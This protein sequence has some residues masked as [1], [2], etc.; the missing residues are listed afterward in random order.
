M[1]KI[2]RLAYLALGLTGLTATAQQSAIYTNGL[3]DFNHAVAL[4]DEEQYLA[5]QLLFEKVKNSSSANYTEVQADCAYYI[6]NCAIRLD[7]VGAE[8]K[9]DEFVKNYPTSAK[10]N[11]A[12]VDVTDY[13]FSK[14][15]YAKALQYAGK[16]RSVTILEHSKQD[17]FLFQ[18]GYSFFYVK[19]PKEA[20]KTLLKVRPESQWGDQATYY[21]G[22]MA[23][24][25]NNYEDAKKHF[26]KID[27]TSSYQ[28]KMGY[29]K[30]DMNFKSGNFEN[31]LTEGLTQL[32]KASEASERSELS[33]I[34]G[35][36][37][38][39]LEQYDKALVYL[40]EYQGKEG[41]WNNTDFYQL[42]YTYYKQGEYDKA[43]EQF[44]KIIQGNNSIAQNAYYHL[45]ESYLHT[46]KKIQA[47]N[48]FKNASEMRFDASIQQDAFLN[49]AKLSYEIGNAFES[50]PSV[51][52][53]FIE[54]YPNSP[55]REELEGLLIDSYITS[56]N[57]K[58]ALRLLEQN[59][60]IGNALVYQKVAFYRGLEL[61]GEGQYDQAIVMFNKSLS[62]KQDLELSARALYW[63]AEA[64]SSLGKYRDAL[65]NFIEFKD[66]SGS[67][68]T[69]EYS[70]IDYNIGYALFK[71]K[72]YPQALEAFTSYVNTPGINSDRKY[73]SYLRIGDANFV[74]GKYWPAMDAYNV[75]INANH[76]DV[77]YA[78]FQ[79]ALSYG[80]VDRQNQKLQELGLFVQDYPN[81]SLA[82][83]AQ[84]EL[85][86][87]Y[88]LLKQ[89]NEAV[90]AFE[91]L[92]T[93]YPNSTRKTRAIL[94][95]GLI[96]YNTNQSEKALAKFKDVVTDSP[97]S[98]EAV[99]AVQN[100][101]LIYMDKGQVDQYAQWVKGLSFI[102]V[103]DS[104][105]ER[106]SF[107]S[108]DRQYILNNSS[109]AIK[110][111]EQY[112]REFPNG[113]NALAANFNL[114]QL[115]FANQ[116][117]SKAQKYYANVVS[118]GKTQYSEISLSRLAEM[119]LKEKKDSQAKQVLLQLEAEAS[120]SQNQIF[121]MS[122]LM[123]LYYQ[124]KDYQKALEYA[125]KVLDK[126]NLDKRVKSDAQLIVARTAFAT[127]DKQKAAQGY[128][129]V[130]VSATGEVAAEALYYQAYFQNEQGQ[131]ELSNQSVQTLAKD[132]SGY[133]YYGAKGLVLMAKNFYALNDSYQATYILDSVIK[134]FSQYKDVVFEAKKELEAIN[135]EEAKRN[136]S[137]VQ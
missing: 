72:N 15:E 39:N 133:S 93:N 17:R 66:A 14:G 45:G 62:E 6:A 95:Q 83:Q 70:N 122:N 120:Q 44:N 36:S 34:V 2:N 9:I 136:S 131:Y 92:I 100:A 10:Q 57:Y 130:L 106:D 77:A 32:D 37:Y 86:V 64:Q 94:R 65:N 28:D 61:Y 98:P 84:Y 42:G 87:T 20:R 121:A 91:T 53:A 5:A 109:E 67:R 48:A 35:E 25:N 63:K 105:I 90:I 18:K 78:K 12:Y 134:N 11:Q 23:Y 115:Y 114:A 51:L 99:E 21:L 119:Y 31:S 137:V 132:Y 96:F 76:G 116:D 79:K 22:Y 4:Y 127:G 73:D 102:E 26:E 16:V 47:L 129:Q 30:A 81:S 124:E 38:F 74:L 135:A 1:R 41:K 125:Q 56:K 13:Y 7:Q 108:A 59:K 112:L 82:D 46:G 71:L 75:I 111:Y 40:Q 103:S 69:P 113:K 68:V 33:K 104:E 89:N 118:F 55:H 54:K 50:A 128:K 60:S 110:G 43:I 8:R 126:P 24:A 88:E 85:G 3:A 19:N 58:D 80:F 29:Y 107:D 117:L 101:R 49:Y 27:V 123:K 52:M 97:N